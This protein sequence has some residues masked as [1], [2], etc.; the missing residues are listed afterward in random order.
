MGSLT[1]AKVWVKIS[2]SAPAI[3]TSIQ[4]RTSTLASRSRVLGEKRKF[5]PYASD[6]ELCNRAS[7]PVSRWGSP[8]CSALPRYGPIAEL[9]SA[10]S[11]S[12]V[13]TKKSAD[14][15]P[16]EGEINVLAPTARDL[17]EAHFTKGVI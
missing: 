8:H 10:P 3:F 15:D 2:I 16:L 14:V 6:N 5:S 7:H 4:A 9:R 12:F 17:V 1:L 11:L 13:Y